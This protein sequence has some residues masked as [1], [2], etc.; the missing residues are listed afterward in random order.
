MAGSSGSYDR[1]AVNLTPSKLI[2]VRLAIK[3]KFL[4]VANLQA[5][6]IVLCSKD[7]MIDNM[8]HAIR[9]ISV[10]ACANNAGSYC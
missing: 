1:F 4:H 2:T 10:P 8:S 7:H 5:L 3:K 9:E 6:N